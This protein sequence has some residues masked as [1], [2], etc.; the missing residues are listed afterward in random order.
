MVIKLI[1]IIITI[2]IILN[3]HVQWYLMMN[4]SVVRIQMMKILWIFLKY[5]ILTNVWWQKKRDTIFFF[6]IFIYLFIYIISDTWRC[7]YAFILISII[8]FFLSSVSSVTCLKKKYIESKQIGEIR[9]K[10]RQEDKSEWMN[11]YIF[12]KNK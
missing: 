2:I 7:V 11:L 9:R 12:L 5:F 4:Q 10:K 3:V 1:I 8:L 6:I